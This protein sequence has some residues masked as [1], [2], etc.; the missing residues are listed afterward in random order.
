MP[1]R[2][3]RTGP[4]TAPPPGFN[5]SRHAWL[6]L[7]MVHPDPDNART[8]LGDLA[9]L[10][11]SMRE[12]GLVQP[13]EVRTT[14]DDPVRDF[15]IDAGHRRYAAAGILGWDRI[16]SIIRPPMPPVDV[17]ERMVAENGQREPLDPIDEGTAFRA[18]FQARKYGS[19]PQLAHRVG[20]SV[21]YVQSRLDLL[22]LPPAEQQRLRKGD[23]TIADAVQVA[24]E[25]AGKKPA[26][27]KPAPKPP[28]PIPGGVRGAIARALRD[29]ADWAR[30]QGHD[31]VAAR[32]NTRADAYEAGKAP[33]P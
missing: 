16:E 30:T 5:L 28:T 32:L 9:D 1:T 12:I 29:E 8:D 4:V 33:L 21:S 26:K 25:V 11:A 6:P 23:L 13:I 31:V 22:D 24:R 20:R 15:V 10:V 18:I 2:E 17:L 3:F 27:K 7:D 14:P 19:I